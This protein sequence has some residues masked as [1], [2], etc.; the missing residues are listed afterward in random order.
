MFSLEAKAAH[1]IRQTDRV[2]KEASLMAEEQKQAI[3]VLARQ[4]QEQG[5]APLQFESEATRT[6][7]E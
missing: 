6:T 4:F 3:L 2:P 5:E 7:R 1:Q